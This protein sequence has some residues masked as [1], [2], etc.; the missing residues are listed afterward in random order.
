LNHIFAPA[1]FYDQIFIGLF[2][3]ASAQPSYCKTTALSAP[4]REPEI[5]EIGRDHPKITK[6]REIRPAH[7]GSE[8][9][10]E[11][12]PGGVDEISHILRRGEAAHHVGVVVLSGQQKVIADVMTPGGHAKSRA[13]AK[14]RGDPKRLVASERA[15]VSA[16]ALGIPFKKSKL[17]C[18]T[19]RGRALALSS[20]RERTV[21]MLGKR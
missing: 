3:N 1:Q 17:V 20:S 15:H 6:R 19:P 21:R 10:R 9:R 5:A 4:R 14:S 2:E 16:G 11:A 18:I 13:L 12:N 8:L 7:A